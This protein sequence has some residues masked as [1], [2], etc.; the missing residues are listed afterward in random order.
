VK[1]T[2]VALVSALGDVWTGVAWS[3]SMNGPLPVRTPR[4]ACDSSR[5][6]VSKGLSFSHWSLRPAPL[7]A[8]L[9]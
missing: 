2:V 6:E 8:L 1:R 4:L 3:R 7:R 9:R 5:K